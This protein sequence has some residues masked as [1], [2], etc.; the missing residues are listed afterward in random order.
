[1]SNFQLPNPC[2]TRFFVHIFCLVWHSFCLSLQKLSARPG[3]RGYTLT[4]R[5]AA[6]LST[7]PTRGRTSRTVPRACSSTPTPASVIGRTTSPRQRAR[8]N[9][10]CSFDFVLF[11]DVS[12]TKTQI[13]FIFC[14]LFVLFFEVCSWQ[15]CPSVFVVVFVVVFVLFLEICKAKSLKII[16]T[17]LFLFVIIMFVKQKRLVK[18]IAPWLSC[19]EVEFTVLDP[20]TFHLNDFELL[21]FLLFF[22]K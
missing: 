20:G 2:T 6:S 5:T 3:Q 18:C 14:F 13:L 4:R 12:K 1:M 15:F 16:S 10:I 21:S 17:V 7:V 19:C 11:F 22:L 8:T 9:E